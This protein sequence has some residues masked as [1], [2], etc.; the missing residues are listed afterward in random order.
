MNITEALAS[1]GKTYRD[2][3]DEEEFSK[4]ITEVKGDKKL[5]DTVK[6]EIEDS[7]KT[8]KDSEKKESGG[9]DK[10]IREVVYADLSEI[11]NIFKHIVIFTNDRDPKNNLTLKNLYDAVDALK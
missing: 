5:D 8:Y 11:E 6:K 10:D 3:S 2:F 9:K 1:A 4:F 7:E